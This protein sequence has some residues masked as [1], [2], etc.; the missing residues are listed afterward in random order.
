MSYLFPLVNSLVLSNYLSDIQSETRVQTEWGRVVTDWKHWNPDILLIVFRT[1]FHCSINMK[2]NRGF[3]YWL[4]PGT[5]Q[6]WFHNKLR[7][8]WKIDLNVIKTNTKRQYIVHVVKQT[9]R[10]NGYMSPEEPG[11]CEIQV[12]I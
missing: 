12:Y 5:I 9:E 7:A 1:C 6:A 11:C 3:K 2:F 10:N 4:V 8:L